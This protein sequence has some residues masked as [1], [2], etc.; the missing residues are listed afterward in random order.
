MLNH[1]NMLAQV[2]AGSSFASLFPNLGT[3]HESIR[4]S[5]ELDLALVAEI[6]AVSNDAVLSGQGAGEIRGLSGARYR[7]EDRLNARCF[8]GGLK[9]LQAGG[10]RPNEI[11]CQPDD[12]NDSGLLHI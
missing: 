11:G 3:L 1:Q 6:P 10:V 12:V 5:P 8:T 2:K 4:L 7:G 9:R